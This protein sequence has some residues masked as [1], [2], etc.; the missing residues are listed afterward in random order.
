MFDLIR[1]PNPADYGEILLPLA[2]CKSYLA[3]DAAIT[4]DDDEIRR[5][6]D[7]A[8]GTIEEYTSVK[9][10]SVDG[11]VWRSESFT[12][13][14][15]KLGIGPV[16]QITA[17]EWLATDGTPVAGVPGD[18]RLVAGGDLLPNGAG[19]WPSGVGGGVQITFGVGYPAGEAPPSLLHAAKL[20]M[21]YLFRH[22]DEAF[23]D[24]DGIPRGII[25][26]CRPFMRV[27]V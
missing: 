26:M 23:D 12:C 15:V 14:A 18:F 2:E 4:D 24:S 21:G 9:L 22:R 11:F 17:I 6:R 27:M 8:I 3:I 10:G 20:L 19:Q 7:A 5:Q 13:G 25:A 16:R 1:A